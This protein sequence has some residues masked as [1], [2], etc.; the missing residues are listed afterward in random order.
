MKRKK[1]LERLHMSI[2]KEAV[3]PLI[4]DTDAKNEADDQYAVIHH[5]LSPSIDV[6]GIV[7]AHFEQKAGYEGGTMEKSYDEVIRLLKLADIDDVPAL[8]GCEAPLQL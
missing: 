1:L 7:A 6:K 2:P 3:V 8:H 5:L 4:I